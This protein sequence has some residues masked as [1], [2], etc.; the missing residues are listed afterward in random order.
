MTIKT[1]IVALLLAGSTTA[2]AADTNGQL[3]RPELFSTSLDYQ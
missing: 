3:R 1:L 2:L